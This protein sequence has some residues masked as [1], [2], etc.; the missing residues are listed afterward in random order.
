VRDLVAVADTHLT[1][2]DPEVPSFVRFLLERGAQA[3]AV[4]HLGDLFNI[5]LGR[6]RFQMEHMAP[7]L[8]AFRE[9]R[10]RGVAT[11]LTEGNRDLHVRRHH[12][13]DVFDVV[14]E[15]EVDVF[16]GGRR[17]RLAHGDLVNVEDRQYRAW[18]RFS[19]SAPVRGGIGLIPSGT[20]IRMAERLEARLR[21]TNVRHKMRFPE[22]PARLYAQ[23][24][25][26]AGCEL[27]LVGHFHEERVVAGGSSGAGGDRG[28]EMIALPDWRSSHSYIHVASDGRWS[29]HRWQERS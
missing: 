1:R 2:Q 19:K 25:A 20:G 3:G 24:A 27:L 26:S 16:A 13:G 12:Q 22:A 17:V 10:R 28:I 5:W 15:E 29:L 21:G 8:D 18:R 6:P 14:A 11:I 7:V 4:A 9:L 23:Q